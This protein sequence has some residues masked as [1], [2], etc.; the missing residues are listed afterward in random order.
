ML[1]GCG[2]GTELVLELRLEHGIDSVHT[3]DSRSNDDVDGHGI[4]GGS[5]PKIDS[6]SAPDREL[7]ELEPELAICVSTDI[8]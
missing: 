7:D 8:S 1:V 3:S 4:N 6:D 5:D 2:H